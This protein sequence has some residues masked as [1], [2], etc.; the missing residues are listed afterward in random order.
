MGN[1]KV[2]MPSKSAAFDFL[3]KTTGRWSHTFRLF[4]AGGV[5]FAP[6]FDLKRKKAYVKSLC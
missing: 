2:L 3:R 5:D 1:D 6:F 4:S